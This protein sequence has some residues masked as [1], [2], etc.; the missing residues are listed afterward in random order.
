MG[1][2]PGLSQQE[3]FLVRLSEVLSVGMHRLL[4]VQGMVLML[5]ERR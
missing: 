4:L 5:N 1:C 3:Q 2:L